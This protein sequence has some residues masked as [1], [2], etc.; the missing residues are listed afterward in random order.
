MRDASTRWVPISSIRHVPNL[1]PS[2]VTSSEVAPA[3][4][5]RA[6]GPHRPPGDAVAEL[7]E[8]GG[9]GLVPL[10]PFPPGSLEEHRAKLPF[11]HVEGRQADVAVRR[12]L[13]ARV[14]DAIGLVESLAG[15]RAHVRARL[16]VFV[17]SSDVRGVEIDLR[18][19]MDHPLGDS[20]SGAGSL[21]DPDRGGGP[22]ALD[23]G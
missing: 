19:T 1:K 9:V 11:A 22:Q 14:D 21:F 5:S 7:L 18:L 8:Q 20:L 10:R 16:L 13:L 4:T 12:P 17:E 15:S 23:V 2:F 3:R 6:F